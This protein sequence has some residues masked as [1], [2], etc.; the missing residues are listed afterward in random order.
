[1]LIEPKHSG[2]GYKPE[3]AKFFEDANLIS[4]VNY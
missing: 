3:P 4:V 2:S 1:M